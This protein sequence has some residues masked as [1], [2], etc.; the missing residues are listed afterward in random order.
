MFLYVNGLF[1]SDANQSAGLSRGWFRVVSDHG[2]REH[3]VSGRNG[4]R[5]IGLRPA[6]CSPKRGEPAGCHQGGAR[7]V[8]GPES[9]SRVRRLPESR[10]EARR[11]NAVAR[12]PD[13]DG[14]KPGR[15]A[16][17]RRTGSSRTGRRT[18]HQIRVGTTVGRPVAG[19]AA[20]STKT[21]HGGLS[22]THGAADGRPSG[23]EGGTGQKPAA[24]AAGSDVD[25]GGADGRCS[26][27]GSGRRWTQQAEPRGRAVAAPA[28]SGNNGRRSKFSR[29]LRPEQSGW[30]DQGR[31]VGLFASAFSRRPS[32]VGLLVSGA[33]GSRPGRPGWAYGRPGRPGGACGKASARHGQGR[34]TRRSVHPA[35]CPARHAPAAPASRK[36][37]P[38]R[39]RQRLS[40][41]GWADRPICWPNLLAQS[42]GPICWPGH[43]DRRCCRQ[44]ARQGARE[45]G[46]RAG[47][48]HRACSR[49]RVRD[50]G[51]GALPALRPVP[52]RP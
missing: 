3:A 9:S 29:R 31:L 22:E 14:G 28:Q 32:R 27:K 5:R 12:L 8:A 19:R 17:K 10:A 39:S 35:A 52:A 48:R 2:Q 25:E 40:V 4:K 13:S 36:V 23:K 1:V 49:G 24:K 38:G 46:H 33:R 45:P 16:A 26:R 18:R 37:T 43:L 42:A 51:R 34:P 20:Q 41:A 44:P 6:P 7:R 21:G 50:P 11:G 30:A 15:T 47:C